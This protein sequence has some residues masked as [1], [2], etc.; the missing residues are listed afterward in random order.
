MS[1][2]VRLGI[3]GAGAIAQ[4]YIKALEVCPVGKLTAIAD[5]RT[6]VA[7]AVSESAQCRS[8]ASHLELAE[9]KECDAVIICT[10]PSAHSD[11]AQAFLERGIPVLCEKPLSTDSATARSVCEQARRQGVGLAMASK[12]RYVEDV[13]RAKSIVASGLVGEVILVENTFAATVDM[14]RR[15]NSDP[16][17]SGGGVLIDNGTHSVDIIRYLIGPIVELTAFE[18]KRVQKLPVEDTVTLFM[19][20]EGGA[21]ATID[22]SWSINKEQD[23][24]IRVY[25]S[26]GI[27][28]VGWGA[29]RYR[30]LTSQDWIVFGRGYD[31]IAAF[32]GQL[33]NFCNHVRN[34]EPLLI[35]PEDAIASVE[36]IQAAYQAL[37]KRQWVSLR[38]TRTRGAVLQMASAQAGL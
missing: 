3:I 2:V 35:S 19:R 36:V 37:H 21:D 34:G 8:Y 24:Y 1:D 17:I 9:G 16:A 32:R 4:S 31:K 25:G 33:A 13:I 27:V 28:Q 12:F 10:P 29:S 14:S 11:I 22:L 7:K 30:Q 5:L 6:D 18:G 15:W 20:T 26:H 38:S 23:S